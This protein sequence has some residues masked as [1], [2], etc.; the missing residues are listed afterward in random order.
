MPYGERGDLLLHVSEVARGI[1]CE[2]VCPVCKKPLVARKG[3]KIVHHFA[4]Y[5]GAQCN[6]ETVLHQLGKRLLHRRITA[7]IESRQPLPITWQ[8]QQCGD[9]H[10]GNLVKAAETAALE[11]DLGVCRPDVTLLTSNGV[12]AAFVEVVVSHRPDENVLAYAARHDVVLVEFH[13]NKA[14][15]LESIARSP[16]LR[17]TS[18]DLCLRPKCST[19]DRPLGRKVLHVVDAECWK[20]HAPVKVAML[21]VDGSMEGP[22]DF[23][24]RDAAVAREQGAILKKNYSKTRDGWYL[25]NSCRRCGAFVGRFYLH[26]YWHLMTSENGHEAGYTCTECREHR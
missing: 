22:E 6:A 15:D 2:C 10:D 4:H 17:P 19:C 26:D 20:C 14:G 1:R 7:A 18:I 25:S 13:V 23:G 21:D 9:Q 16:L 8:C 24:D 3:G 11:R 5:P 12:P